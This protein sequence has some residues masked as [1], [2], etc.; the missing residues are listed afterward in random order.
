MQIVA[1]GIGD[2]CLYRTHPGANLASK[3]PNVETAHAVSAAGRL[4][5]TATVA[6]ATGLM[7]QT[8]G[9]AH[10]RLPQSKQREPSVR[11][12][13]AELDGGGCVGR[14]DAVSDGGM[15]TSRAAQ[16]KQRLPRASLAN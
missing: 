2:T 13:G 10:R 9:W 3:G 6:S 4:C 15:G 8:A 5:R 16:S 1:P 7:S 11:R 14:G 12:R